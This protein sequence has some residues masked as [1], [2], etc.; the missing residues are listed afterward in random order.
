MELQKQPDEVYFRSRLHELL[1]RVL[2]AHAVAG[3]QLSADNTPE[4]LATA[5]DQLLDI[6]LRLESDSRMGVHA[7]SAKDDITELG[8]YIIGLLLKLEHWLQHYHLD[9]QQPRMA[10]VQLSFAVWVARQGGELMTLEP[11]VD[12]LALFANRTLKPE[13]LGQLYALISE[14][15]EA[16]SPVIQQDLEKANPGRPW[17]VLNLNRAIVATRS[18]DPEAMK[19]AFDSLTRR[20]PEEAA[21][22][23][24]EG[25]EQMEA[26]NYP[27]HVRHV[28]EGYYKEWNRK[29]QL[30]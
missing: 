13:Q 5:I 6:M 26:L 19:Q 21:G 27:A 2:Q 11:V 14:I 17:R 4:T 16:V 29:H 23:F 25:M 24:A 10:E 3:D 1:D 7:G 22:F 18:H 15:M 12:A 30:H 20:L 9:D 28:L 8:E